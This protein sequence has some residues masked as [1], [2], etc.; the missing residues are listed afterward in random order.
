MIECSKMKLV[1]QSWGLRKRTQSVLELCNSSNTIH[2]TLPQ[3]FIFVSAQKNY[4]FHILGYFPSEHFHIPHLICLW[5]WLQLKGWT[6]LFLNTYTCTW[7]Q[8]QN[9]K[10]FSTP[11]S[12]WETHSKEI[13]L[14]STQTTSAHLQR[15]TQGLSRRNT[16]ET[17]NTFSVPTFLSS[18][19][20]RALWRAETAM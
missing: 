9:R 6:S 5:F 1:L 8:F 15:K 13:S 2:S 4:P 20:R 11:S 18:W 16:R 14:T 10:S 19:S 17:N 3:S 12:G 7:P